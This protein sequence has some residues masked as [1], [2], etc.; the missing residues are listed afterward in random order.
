VLDL[1]GAA[2]TL[3][4]AEAYT[5]ATSAFIQRALSGSIHDRRVTNLIRNY[6]GVRRF[7]EEL[8]AAL[9]PNSWPARLAV[10]LGVSLEVVVERHEVTIPE[11]GDVPPLSIAFASD[12]HAGPTTPHELLSRAADALAALRPDLLLL[13]GDF[14]SLRADYAGELLHL[15][16]DIPA[17]LGRYTVLGNHDHWAG[18]GHIEAAIR[19]AGIEVL[20]N[21]HVRLPRPYGHVSV[22]GLDDHTSGHPDGAA[23]L[24]GAGTVRLLLMHAPSGLLDISGRAFSLALCGHTHGGQIAL[25]G[26]RPLVVPHGA[27]SR[28]HLAGRYELEGGR[29][30]LVSRGVGFSTLPFRWNSPPDILSVTLRGSGP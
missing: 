27:L 28:R 16:G 2:A 29:T 10:R 26:G 11:L 22:C 23:A 14:V 7:T 1:A 3:A 8:L 12:F 9:M 20:T 24:D 5:A 19:A 17:P 18:T 13:G 25:P 15:L 21:R 4:A 30:L 6:H